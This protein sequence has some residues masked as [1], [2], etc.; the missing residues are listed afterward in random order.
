MQ[1][2][3]S[4]EPTIIIKVHKI[5][6]KFFM[7]AIY[8]LTRFRKK[9]EMKQYKIENLSG[10]K[11]INVFAHFKWNFYSLTQKF[12]KKKWEFNTTAVDRG[13]KKV[14]SM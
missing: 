3:R 14:I 4:V 10:R 5:P 1:R 12:I 13:R 6:S 9:E 11:K 2:Q 7:T 8:V